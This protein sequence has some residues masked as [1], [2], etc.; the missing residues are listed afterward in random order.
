MSITME[1]EFHDLKTK[2]DEIHRLLI[3]NE[4]DEDVGILSRLKKN[5]TEM[6]AINEWKS[7]IT[8]FAYGMVVPATYGVFDVIKTI[9][10]TV[11]K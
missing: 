11:G 7:R 6:R 1:K 4:H 2:V 8:Y 10:N 5:E 3:G 9:I